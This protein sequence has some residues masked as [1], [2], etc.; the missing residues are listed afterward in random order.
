MQRVSR[1]P[2]GH[3]A[4]GCLV[5]LTDARL[6]V[7]RSRIASVVAGALPP[8]ELGEICLRQE[9]RLA[10]ARIADSLDRHGGALLADDV[11]RGKTFV[12]LAVARRWSRPLV[13]APASLRD[14]WQQ[15]MRRA[16]V[17]C[18]LVSHESLS[19]RIP[20]S[21]EPDGIIVDESHRFR[22]TTARRHH[23]LA[24]LA[25]RVPVLLMS[26][27][28]L[29]NCP[30]DLSAQL[31]IFL[32][33]RALALDAEA[34]ARFVI[35]TPVLGASSLP[36]IAPP[37]WMRLEADDSAILRAIAELPAPPPA[38]DAGDAGV[39]RIITLVRAWA[40]SRAA[41][42]RMVGRRLAAAI[43][44]EQSV[45]DG[46]WP[47]RR[48]LRS[49]Y[50]G[51]H[52]TQLGF[53]S[54]LAEASVQG[55]TRDELLRMAVAEREGL[56]RIGR[57]MARS[58][59]PDVCRVAA[60][61]TLRDLLGGARMLA[62]SELASTVSA[63]WRALQG[64][65][66]VGML[67]SHEARIASGR[68]SRAQ[69][70]ARFAPR[71]QGAS[72]PHRREDVT[73]LLATDLLSEGVNLQ[74]G[75]VVVHLDLP[76]NPARLAQ[77]VG[78]LRR[79]DGA[80]E[81]R[82]YLM[83][84]PASAEMLLGVESRL[85]RKLADAERTIGRGIPVMPALE[86]RSPSPLDAVSGVRATVASAEALGAMYARVSGWRA[87]HERDGR[88]PASPVVAA[89]IAS[90]S[91][92]LAAL[93]GGRLLA[94]VDGS[95]PDDGATATVAVR[96]AD[97]PARP[98]RA[99][100][101]SAA[102]AALTRYLDAEQV[103]RDCGLDVAVD[104]VSRSYERRI[105]L[106]AAS[107]ARH[108]RAAVLTLAERLR[109]ALRGPRSLGADRALLALLRAPS[110][111]AGGS[112]WL[113]RAIATA[114]SSRTSRAAGGDSSRLVALIVFGPP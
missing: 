19:R 107:A 110:D 62:F 34:L 54:F 26:A 78:R 57:E 22:S 63:Y 20:P 16:G 44:M 11:G 61:R 30:R 7:A 82:T 93:R 58:P 102:K 104:D 25:A 77:R 42:R 35:R 4:V 106:Q 56:E 23:A 80:T 114:T 79:P 52:A 13:V 2:R 53:A 17:P 55:E 39:L 28:P 96:L 59:D 9:Q 103:E 83:P 40:S 98:L 1:S 33:N 14:T 66:A 36:A 105:A 45:S 37:R 70:L 67:T 87:E 100:E 72:P 65:P 43:A 89:A 31:A 48:E 51:E 97:G 6:R 49:W 99:G 111:R 71:A 47:T 18:A 109:D 50:G 94:S 5:W 32:G 24:A 108:E 73:L 85:R 101:S 81:V 46:V 60:L 69:L 3:R 113:R 74:D 90:R 10:V 86:P 84:P 95:L 8:A 75:S 92:W 68:L 88:P 76:W 29:Q 64:D 91:G 41:L 38:I 15:A 27:T 21:V 12:A 112:E